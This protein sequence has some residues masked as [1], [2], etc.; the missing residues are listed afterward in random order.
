MT[1]WFFSA[2][3]FPFLYTSQLP[4]FHDS[5]STVLWYSTLP[6]KL[7]SL[8][9]K[10]LWLSMTLTEHKKLVMNIYRQGIFI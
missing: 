2:P 4:R 5:S 7:F 6:V 9:S 1:S 3:N 10:M 8:Y